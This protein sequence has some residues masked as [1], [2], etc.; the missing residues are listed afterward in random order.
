MQNSTQE[1]LLGV[2]IDNKLTF[3]HYVAGL[4]Q[5]ASNKLYALSRIAPFMDQGK[6]RYLMRAFIN[7]IL[8]LGVDVP[9]PTTSSQNDGNV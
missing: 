7:S 4:C 5:K 1:K 6:L 9:Q 3:E 2:T 8:S